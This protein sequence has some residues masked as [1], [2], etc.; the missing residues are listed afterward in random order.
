[1]TRIPLDA[2]GWSV[3]LTTGTVHTRYAGDH[4]GDSY[5][6]RTEK[7]VLNLLAGRKPTICKRC[8]SSPRYADTTPRPPQRRRVP[9]TSS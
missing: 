1:M 6:T 3:N 7:G 5:R 8:F 4:A 2:E 9:A